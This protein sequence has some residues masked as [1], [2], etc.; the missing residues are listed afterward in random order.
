MKLKTEK[1]KTEEKLMNVDKI[2][3]S[4]SIEN[5]DLNTMNSHFNCNP[6]FIV[7]HSYKAALLDK[8]TEQ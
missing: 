6:G 8:L 3:L 4:I 1:L 2:N 5:I 7:N